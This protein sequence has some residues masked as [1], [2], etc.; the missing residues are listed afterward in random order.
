[1]TAN[2]VVFEQGTTL[3]QIG[4]EGGCILR[5]DEYKDEA[6]ITLEKDGQTA[7]FS[8]TC[9]ISGWMCHTRF[10]STLSE[11][12]MAYIQMQEAIVTIVELIPYK[13]DAELEQK[14]RQVENAIS[15]FVECF[16]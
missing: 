2:W 14:M 4:S 3:G 15:H 5:D 9:G 8:I 1:M 7:P 11:A 13:T 12:E 10:F 6:R 16:P